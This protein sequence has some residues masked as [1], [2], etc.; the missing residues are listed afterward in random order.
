M[1]RIVE[2]YCLY[3]RAYTRTLSLSHERA[4][5][6][7][8]YQKRFSMLEKR[9]DD[10]RKTIRQT[11]QAWIRE[12]RTRGTLSVSPDPIPASELHFE[13]QGDDGPASGDQ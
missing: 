11:P 13:E 2:N 1:Q 10:Q 8:M 6:Y 4:H 9:R 3:T 7:R 5:A 12:N